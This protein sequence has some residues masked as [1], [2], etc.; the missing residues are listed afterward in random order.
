MLTHTRTHTSAHIPTLI[1]RLSANVFHLHVL[2]LKPS[3]T[4]LKRQTLKRNY[5]IAERSFPLAFV[6]VWQQRAAG[7]SFLPMKGFQ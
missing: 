5:I 6:R 4:E 3:S 1:G 7:Y 2:F